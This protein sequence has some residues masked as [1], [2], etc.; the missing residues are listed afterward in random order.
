MTDLAKLRSDL[1]FLK[2]ILLGAF[3]FFAPVTW[4]AMNFWFEFYGFFFD[5]LV[6]V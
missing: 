5:W 4:F 2:L 1:S 6:G 3:F